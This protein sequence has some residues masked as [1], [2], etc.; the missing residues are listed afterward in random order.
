MKGVRYDAEGPD[1]VGSNRPTPRGW[2][3]SQ[4]GEGA[5]RGLGGVD[6]AFQCQREYDLQ[7]GVLE[8]SHLGL[9]HANGVTRGRSLNIL[10]PQLSPLQ[11]DDDNSTCLT[12]VLPR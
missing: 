4:P 12:E 11:K 2:A 3:L 5:C 8:P 7:L 1:W 10:E 6:C 9:S